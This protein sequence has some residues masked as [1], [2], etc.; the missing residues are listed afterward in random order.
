[1]SDT[2]AAFIRLLAFDV[3]GTI[4]DWR[5]SIIAEGEQLGRKKGLSIDWGR[6]ADAWRER[7]RPSL[8]RVR[9]GEL[10]WTKLDVLHRQS[11]ENVLSTFKVNSLNEAEKNEFNRVWHRL[12]SWPDAVAGLAR[13]KSRY[14]I[15]TLSNG[16]ISLLTDMAKYEG[17]PWDCVLS[18]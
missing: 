16:N 5:S 1:M 15:T 9:S 6:F 2:R 11:L 4:V 14:V 8:D 10:P 12:R 7:Y 13:L 17:L 18:A 3:F